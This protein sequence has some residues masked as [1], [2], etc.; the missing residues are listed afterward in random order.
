MGEEL[1][2]AAAMLRSDPAAG[3]A[4]E[5]LAKVLRNIVASPSDPKFRCAASSAMQHCAMSDMYGGLR[6]RLSDSEVYACG[7]AC[8]LPRHGGVPSAHY[9]ISI[10]AQD[11][12]DFSPLPLA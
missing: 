9:C 6:I 1:Q 10:C 5:L 12:G 8:P 7:N 11:S 2:S 3:P 4:A